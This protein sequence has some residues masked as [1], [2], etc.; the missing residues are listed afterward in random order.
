M[1]AANK[2]ILARKHIDRGVTPFKLII[3]LAI[4]FGIGLSLGYVIIGEAKLHVE[5]T[6]FGS[7]SQTGA[8]DLI[9]LTEM[10][11]P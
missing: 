9:Q 3:W 8:D 1:G 5:E 6:Q 11:L 2:V 7:V 10:V 4:G